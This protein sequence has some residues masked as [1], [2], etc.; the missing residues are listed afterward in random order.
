MNCNIKKVSDDDD[1][2]DHDDNEFI[3]YLLLR[4]RADIKH[5][6]QLIVRM[7]SINSWKLVGKV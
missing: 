6:G 7:V 5:D 4:T 1:N 3:E 2:R